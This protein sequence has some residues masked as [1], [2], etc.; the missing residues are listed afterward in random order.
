[1]Y[2]LLQIEELCLQDKYF[3]VIY[4]EKL[5]VTNFNNKA[6][7]ELSI[8]PALGNR[9]NSFYCCCCFKGKPNSGIP[10]RPRG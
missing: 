3:L 1:M 9:V 8:E 5:L 2:K 7:Q 4:F 6:N 10:W